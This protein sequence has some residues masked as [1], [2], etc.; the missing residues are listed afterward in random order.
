ME[1]TKYLAIDK[2]IISEGVSFKFNIFMLSSN[3]QMNCFKE[4]G[5]SFTNSDKNIIDSVDVLYVEEGQ[6]NEYEKFYETFLDNQESIENI[7]PNKTS[8]M[9]QQASVVLSNLLSNPEAKSN[10]NDSKEVVKE[11]VETVISDT[12]TLKTIMD[13]V[14]YDYYTHTHSINVS[15]Y[16]LS[17]GAYMKMQP[18]TLYELGESALLHDLGKSKISPSIITKNGTLTNQE[19][20]EIKKH[21]DIGYK[22]ALNL[23][24]DNKN[25]LDGI[26]YHHEKMDGTGYPSGLKGSEIPLFARIIGVCDVFDAVTSRRTYK[27][28]I[29]SFEAIKLMKLEMN[30]H[31]DI[32]LLNKMIMMFQ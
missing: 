1:S 30:N 25:V 4:N 21:S 31:I 5:N 9:Y 12:F 18:E 24:I 6:H 14:T 19:F 32:K 15:M 27:E 23:G 10:Y 22:L 28:A 2:K 11:M 17:L 7:K 29:T 8:I 13:I 26:R 16:A 20:I 3:H